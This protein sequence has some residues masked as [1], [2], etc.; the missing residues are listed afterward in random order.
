[1]RL[2][3]G[4]ELSQNLPVERL[5]EWTSSKDLTRTKDGKTGIWDV[6]STIFTGRF[7]E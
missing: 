5:L 4:D 6:D 2:S 1:M 7:R 3:G